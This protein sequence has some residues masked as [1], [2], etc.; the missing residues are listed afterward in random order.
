MILC[1]SFGATKEPFK[2]IA[3]VLVGQPVICTCSHHDAMGDDGRTALG[4]GMPALLLLI[5]FL[6]G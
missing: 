5:F 1:E 2:D 6:V 4:K 3:G